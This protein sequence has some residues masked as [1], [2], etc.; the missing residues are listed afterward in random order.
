MGPFLLFCC[1]SDPRLFVLR[2]LRVPPAQ[3]SVVVAHHIEHATGMVVA[4]MTVEGPDSRIIGIEGDP[5][6]LSFRHEHGVAFRPLDGLVV[7]GRWHMKGGAG[8]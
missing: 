8:C 1:H 2:G 7:D 5:D 3:I 6:A 4:D